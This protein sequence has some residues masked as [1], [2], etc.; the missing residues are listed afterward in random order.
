MKTTEKINKLLE[1][2]MEKVPV[3][4]KIMNNETLVVHQIK[5]TT[6]FV[7]P[8]K[9]FLYVLTPV[10]DPY[11]VSDNK[12]VIF[13]GDILLAIEEFIPL[14]GNIEYFYN[15]LKKLIK[16]KRKD[17]KYKIYIDN[18]IVDETYTQN[19]AFIKSRS[20]L[21]EIKRNIRKGKEVMV[22]S[23]LGGRTIFLSSNNKNK[24]H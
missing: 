14:P 21:S 6:A 5:N 22:K 2:Y 3:E 24:K 19:E 13:H 9:A 16:T 8:S 20:Y 15:T 7:S 4:L 11:E 10:F 18:I 23:P 12:K 1:K 17:S